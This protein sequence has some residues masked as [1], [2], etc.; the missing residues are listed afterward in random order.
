MTIIS[1]FAL[2]PPSSFLSLSSKV[3]PAMLGHKHHRAPPRASQP[4]PPQ[5]PDSNSCP[6]PPQPGN[7]AAKHEDSKGTNVPTQP[8]PAGAQ[9]QG[10]KPRIFPVAICRARPKRRRS[11]PWQLSQNP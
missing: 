10:P 4:G 1:I 6:W 11:A 8:H 3:N 9:W 5:I 7:N 2:S